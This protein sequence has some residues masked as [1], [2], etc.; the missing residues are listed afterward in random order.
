M[1]LFFRISS[2]AGVSDLFSVFEGDCSEELTCFEVPTGLMA[3]MATISNAVAGVEYKM[4]ARC[5][6]GL[7]VVTHSN[8][9]AA[10]I[11]KADAT[12]SLHFVSSFVTPH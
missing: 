2:V 9:Q 10:G 3:S 6:F 7:R 5:A 4:V 12:S 11:H 1:A 8:R